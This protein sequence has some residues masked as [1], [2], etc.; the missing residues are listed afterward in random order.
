MRPGASRVKRAT[1]VW[2]SGLVKFRKTRRDSAAS[3]A[4]VIPSRPR[5][6]PAEICERRSSTNAVETTPPR[7]VRIVPRCSTT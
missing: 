1:T 3:G 6:P 7:I 2:P 5:S 4:N